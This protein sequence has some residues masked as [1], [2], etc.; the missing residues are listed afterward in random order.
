MYSRSS[1]PVRFERDCAVVLV[2]QGENVTLPAGS[3]GYITQAL[4]GSY[5]VFVEGNL[6]RLAGRDADAIG[7]EP[8]VPLELPDGADD[9]AVERMVWNQLRTCFDPEI[10][11]NVVDLGLVYEA[12]VHPAD[13][14]AR[15]IEVKMTL[16]APGCGMGE[17]LVDDVRSKLELIPTVR[18]ADVELVFDPPWNRSMMSE[19]ARLETGM[20]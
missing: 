14:G 18:E 13:D 8:P 6:F 5:T 15:T 17:I 11:I 2:P 3:A 10:P 7:K 19:A 1:E 4:G 9:A 16:T 20:L 12:V